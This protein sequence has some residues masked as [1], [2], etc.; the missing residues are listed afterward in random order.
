MSKKKINPNAKAARAQRVALSDAISFPADLPAACRGH[1]L[2]TEGLRILFLQY[3]VQGDPR[4]DA[5]WVI[6]QVERLAFLVAGRR[7]GRGQQAAPAKGLVVQ[8]SAPPAPAVAATNDVMIDEVCADF[9][10]A[11]S[12]AIATAPTTGRF[13]S[14]GVLEFELNCQRASDLLEAQFDIV[15]RVRK[16]PKL[17]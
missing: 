5:E 2:I 13:A 8:P 15:V 17:N 3:G 4:A 1:W 7:S 10:K 12:A 14:G 6:G 9:R 11:V 16:N